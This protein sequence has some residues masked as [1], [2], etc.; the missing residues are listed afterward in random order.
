MSGE[1]ATHEVFIESD[2]IAP[3]GMNCGLCLAY[4]RKKNRCP[5]CHGDDST[6]AKSC[7]ACRIKNCD[8]TTAGNKAGARYFCF[9]CARFPCPRLRQLD[10][11]YRTKYGMSMLR[12][13]QSI[14]TVGLDAFVDLES[15][16]WKCTQCGGVVCVHKEHC[17]HCGHARGKNVAG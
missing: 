6:K 16:R 1:V 5:G 14:Q 11:R 15:E 12:N 9:Q 4:L 10:K 17:L 8:E 3:C 2:L 13:L 7:L